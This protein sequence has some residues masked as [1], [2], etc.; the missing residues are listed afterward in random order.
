MRYIVKEIT[1]A[2]Y[3]EIGKKITIDFKTIPIIYYINF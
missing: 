1:S 2:V 3:F